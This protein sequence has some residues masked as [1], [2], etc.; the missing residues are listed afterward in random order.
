MVGIRSTKREHCCINIDYGSLESHR[1]TTVVMQV[2]ACDFDV[3]AI[4]ASAG[5]TWYNLM[6]LLTEYRSAVR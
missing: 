2:I 6:R 1:G 4:E 3:Q 5:V